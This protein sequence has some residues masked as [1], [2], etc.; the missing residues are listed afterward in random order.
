[1]PIRI[2]P[3]I[4]C[5]AETVRSNLEVLTKLREATGRAAHVEGNTQNQLEE[6]AE[7]LRRVGNSCKPLGQF[8]KNPRTERGRF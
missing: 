4:W 2:Q 7:A 8:S 1:M 5:G 3:T 6:L